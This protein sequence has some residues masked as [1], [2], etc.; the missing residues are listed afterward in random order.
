MTKI[1]FAQ[2]VYPATTLAMM[3][4]A[5][6]AAGVPSA[7]ALR[8]TRLSLDEL[9]APTT[10]ISLNQ[11]IAGYRTQSGSPL[12]PPGPNRL[13]S[14]I[15]VSL[16]GMHG[17]AIL[18]STDFRRTHGLR[19]PLSSAGGA[20]RHHLVL[21]R[22]AST[23]SGRLNPPASANR[24]PASEAPQAR[25]TIGNVAA[26]TAASGQRSPIVNSCSLG[27]PTVPRLARRCARLTALNPLGG[28]FEP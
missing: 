9:H 19:R 14:N 8:G 21:Q 16:Y 11:L 5:L 26:A 7:E 1:G 22:H 13:G 28:R 17:Y 3:M 27:W 6:I 15:H 20:T 23:A 10:Q 25:P 12:T 18:C 2:R 24:V 4:D